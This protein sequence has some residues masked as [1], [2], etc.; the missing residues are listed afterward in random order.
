MLKHPANIGE[1]SPKRAAKTR[2]ISIGLHLPEKVFLKSRM[3][4]YSD[5]GSLENAF[6]PAKLCRFAA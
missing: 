6:S 3:R 5:F 4:A 1:S 2:R